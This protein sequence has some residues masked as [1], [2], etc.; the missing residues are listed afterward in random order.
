MSEPILRGP[1]TAN[2]VELC[3]WCRYYNKNNRYPTEIE[4]R[5]IIAT[6]QVSQAIKWKRSFNNSGMANPDFESH[7]SAALHYIMVAEHWNISC[8]VGSLNPDILSWETLP[9][10]WEAYTEANAEVAQMIIYGLRAKDP[11]KYF[12]GSRYNPMIIAEGIKK[13]VTMLIQSIPS[14]RRLDSLKQAGDI[15]S[16]RL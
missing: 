2:F 16:G 5:F 1:E 7:A 14:H 11:T 12:R 9:I 15:M 8:L 6:Y 4:R 3:E 10:N 13:L